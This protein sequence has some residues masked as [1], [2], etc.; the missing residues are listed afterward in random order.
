VI[1]S[2]YLFRHALVTELREDGWDTSDIAAVIGESTADTV[3]WYGLRRRGGGSVKPKKIAVVAGSIQTAVPVRPPD[4][5]GLAI[6]VS[7]AKGSSKAL[8]K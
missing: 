1:L 7:R 4:L 8:R 2:A 3:A 6:Q 5:S